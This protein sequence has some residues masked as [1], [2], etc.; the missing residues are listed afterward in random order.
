MTQQ[1][2]RFLN[3]QPTWLMILVSFGLLL[4]AW[5]LLVVIGDYPAFILPG[6]MDVARQFVTVAADGRLLYHSLITLSEIIPGLI[7]GCLFAL[8]MGYLLA[9]SPLADR[10]ISPYL[11]ASQAIPV[12]AIAPST[13]KSLLCIR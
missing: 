9:K 3:R 1:I 11:I 13:M 4:L 12:I 8:P 2:L 7:I 6:P 10:L 5:H